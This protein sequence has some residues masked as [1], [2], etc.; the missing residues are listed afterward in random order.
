M[1][2]ATR[3]SYSF[4]TLLEA[5]QGGIVLPRSVRNSAETTLNSTTWSRPR[6]RAARAVPWAYR[7]K[8][9]PPCCCSSTS[10]RRCWTQPAKKT[11]PCVNCQSIH[12]AVPTHCWEQQPSEERAKRTVPQHVQ[13]L[14]SRGGSGSGARLP[15]VVGG[16]STPLATH[17]LAHQG[18]RDNERHVGHVAL[19][20]ARAQDSVESEW[21][22][23]IG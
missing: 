13:R 20:H 17:P 4:C 19:S 3:S 11:D 2:S 7:G 12:G 21:C 8:C 15:C 22:K 16:S 14:V 1:P 5:Q 9:A 6:R 10:S 23:G 18:A